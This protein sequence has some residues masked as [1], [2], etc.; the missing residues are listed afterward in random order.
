MTRLKSGC[1]V[2]HGNGQPHGCELG[3]QVHLPEWA[4]RLKIEGLLVKVA[5]EADFLT[6][7]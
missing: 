6:N 5:E 7:G 2:G 4:L 3:R 1:D